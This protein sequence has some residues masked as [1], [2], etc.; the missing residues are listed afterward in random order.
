MDN[1]IE[2]VVKPGVT[3]DM[4]LEVIKELQEIIVGMVEV[5]ESE[6]ENEAPETETETAPVTSM[7]VME[8]MPDMEED[9]MDGQMILSEAERRMLI[10]KNIWNGTF[11]PNSFNK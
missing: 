2:K 7:P 9:K 6:T 11:T 10:G 3:T 5:E 1:N 4:L 8:G